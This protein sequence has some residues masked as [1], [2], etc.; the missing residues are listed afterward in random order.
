MPQDHPNAAAYRNKSIDY[1][2]DI[3]SLCGPDRAV[4]DGVEMHDEAAAAM[5]AEF[6]SE[7][8]SSSKSLSSSMPKKQ[9]RDR[10]A[11]AV[12]NFTECFRDYVQ[13]K[14]KETPKP[15]PQEIHDVVKNVEGIGR[16]Q[17]MR[18]TR[19]FTNGPI[20]DFEMLKALPNDEKLDW[21]LEC[22]NN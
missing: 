9:K 21:V 20:G 17:V 7:G 18:A 22:L 19:M 1:W 13:S 14:P 16:H 4:G 6:E 5:D 10:L 12:A 11:E 8:G 15:T 3:C 2:D